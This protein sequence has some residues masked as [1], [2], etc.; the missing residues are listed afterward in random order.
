MYHFI[1]LDDK[2]LLLTHISIGLADIIRRYDSI[3]V[4]LL[5]TPFNFSFEILSVN[6]SRKKRKE[7]LRNIYVY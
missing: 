5:H 2:K 3:K 7:L 4:V 6:E 1:K